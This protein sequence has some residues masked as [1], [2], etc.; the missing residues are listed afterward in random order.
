MKGADKVGNIK[1][2]TPELILCCEPS[3]PLHQ[4]PGGTKAGAQNKIWLIFWCVDTKQQDRIN[5]SGVA[6]TN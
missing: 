5:Y 2:Y 4:V 1:Y 6:D 3:H